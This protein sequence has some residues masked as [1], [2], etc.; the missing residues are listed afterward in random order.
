MGLR[1]LRQG[2]DDFAAGRHSPYF[3]ISVYEAPGLSQAFNKLFAVSLLLAIISMY[4]GALL[5]DTL[6]ETK[7]GSSLIEFTLQYQNPRNRLETLQS[8]DGKSGNHYLICFVITIVLG[9]VI[10]ILQVIVYFRLLYESGVKAMLD[11]RAVWG[12]LGT[13]ILSAYTL[14]VIFLE[15]VEVR[16]TIGFSIIFI[17]PFFPFICSFAVFLVA[18][19]LLVPSAAVIK[20]AKRHLGDQN[21]DF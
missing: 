11:I 19:I 16:A 21:G 7:L 10:G 18:T 14:W 2:K 13:L 17:W 15:P 4:I 20:L 5:S 1:I 8:Y 6:L 3:P 12:L 9:V